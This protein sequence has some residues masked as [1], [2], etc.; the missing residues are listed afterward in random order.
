MTRFQQN[1]AVQLRSDW[2]PRTFKAT[3]R[4]AVARTDNDHAET[5]D[6]GTFSGFS[7]TRLSLSHSEW[8]VC[9]LRATLPFVGAHN[10]TDS[11]WYA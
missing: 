3:A 2:I 7:R 1:R 11:E 4:D 10:G 6:G 9:A 8:Q 5:G